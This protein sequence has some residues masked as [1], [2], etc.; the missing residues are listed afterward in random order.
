MK[1]IDYLPE[2]LRDYLLERQRMKVWSKAYDL[3]KKEKY[4]EAAE[5]YN[6][7]APRLLE[8]NKVGFGEL[9][10]CTYCNYAF[11][12]FIKAK[13]VENALQQ[14]RNALKILIQND[15]K[16]I[17][18]NSGEQANDL[19]KMVVALYGE[20]YIAEGDTLSREIN[21]QFEKYDVPL[22]CIAAPAQRN[23]FPSICPQCGGKL[24]YSPNHKAIKC[25]FC[26][27]TIYSQKE[28]G[29]N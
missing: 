19:L 10:Y 1:F 25:P 8:Y 12:L 29:S 4:Q 20:G 16:W 18:Y 11:G 3:A 23:K 5:V 17:K 21:E 27:I 26:E 2:F 14:A 15:G 6:N 9:M 7:F 28:E 13:D 22:R 24:P